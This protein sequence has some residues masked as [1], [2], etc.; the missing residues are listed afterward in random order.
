[1]GVGVILIFNIM[2]KIILL[3]LSSML[4]IS[5]GETKREKEARIAKETQQQIQKETA[6]I[7][8]AWNNAISEFK[9]EV[10]KSDSAMSIFSSENKLLLRG[11]DWKQKLWSKISSKYRLQEKG[12]QFKQKFGQD[13]YNIL[14]LKVDDNFD[15]KMKYY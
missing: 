7:I 12:N 5:C 4:M 1:M 8:V 15:K 3:L 11:A 13:E 6:K 14:D 10:D 9:K 2:K